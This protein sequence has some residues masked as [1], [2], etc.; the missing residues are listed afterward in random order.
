MTAVEEKQIRRAMC[1]LGGPSAMFCVFFLFYSQT[2][3]QQ[4][5]KE[6]YI[7]QSWYSDAR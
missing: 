7:V 1:L 2:L 3:Q 6:R 4:I 5:V